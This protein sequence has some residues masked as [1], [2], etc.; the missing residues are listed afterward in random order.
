MLMSDVPTG[1]VVF[2]D[3]DNSTDE[4]NNTD[5]KTFAGD[6]FEIYQKGFFLKNGSIG[7]FALS[8]VDGVIKH[9]SQ[10]NISDDDRKIIDMIGDGLITNYF[11]RII[12]NQSSSQNDSQK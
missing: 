2:L 1:N 5:W 8:K 10:G 7:N 3:K 6:I 11:H 9:I 4:L 12:D